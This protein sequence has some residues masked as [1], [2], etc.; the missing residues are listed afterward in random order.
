MKSEILDDFSDLEALCEE[1]SEAEDARVREL[2][3]RMTDKWSL[4]TLG[5]LAH[6]GAPLRFSRVLERVEGISQKSLTKTLR[7]LEGDALVTRRIYAEVPPRVEYAITSLGI[8]L[9]NQVRP[10]WMWVV[11]NVGR[12]SVKA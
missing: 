11:R 3:T 2:L 12:F 9:L 10:L 6:E 4:W 8:E 7:T 1:L 5:I